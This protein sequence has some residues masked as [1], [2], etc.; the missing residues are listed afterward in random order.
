MRSR[1]SKLRGPD[2]PRSVGEEKN[3]ASAELE[4]VEQFVPRME[5]IAPFPHARLIQRNGIREF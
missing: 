2:T 1:R 4:R 3:P 5:Q